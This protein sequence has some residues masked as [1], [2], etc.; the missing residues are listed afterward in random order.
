[1]SSIPHPDTHCQVKTYPDLSA[2]CIKEHL[3]LSLRLW[4]I[5]RQEQPDG[6]GWLWLKDVYDLSPGGERQTARWLKDGDGLFWDVVEDSDGEKVR[7]RSLERVELALGVLDRKEPVYVSFGDGKLKTWR[8]NLYA[9]LFAGDDYTQISQE[10][11]S[12]LF[13]RSA[14]TLFEWSKGK[15]L[16]VRHNMSWAE[17]DGNPD[18]Y[19][20]GILGALGV[21]DGEE[22]TDKAKN[23]WVE[24]WDDLPNGKKW[25]YRRGDHRV[26]CWTLPNGYRCDFET[27]PR[28]TLQ[29]QAKRKVR[30]L[31]DMGRGSPADFLKLFYEDP[32]AAARALQE[33]DRPEPLY[34]RSGGVHWGE[35]HLWQYCTKTVE[36]QPQATRP[37][38]Q[39]LWAQRVSP[40]TGEMYYD[41]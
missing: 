34:F 37:A 7:L 27:G 11:L 41:C 17:Y 1:M 35:R 10:K 39:L 3:D 40:W 31:L 38:A 22:E 14:R 28:T 5:L 4:Y 16:E 25:H 13:G 19:P 30:R 2:Y 9:S 23:M 24:H 18:R 12:E 33:P 20:A 26:V 36:R 29:K 8:A 15:H 21:K 6:R 32:N